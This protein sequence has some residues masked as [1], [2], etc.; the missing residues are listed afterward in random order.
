[1]T[2]ADERPH[3]PPPGADTQ[4]EESWWFDFVAPDGSLA[5]FARLGLWPAAGLA[6]YWA[7]LVGDD[8]PYLLVRDDEVPAPRP[9]RTEIRAEGLWSSLECE[10]PFDHWTVGLEAFAVALDDPDEAWAGERGDRI[11]LGFDLEWEAT[12]PADGGLSSY[13][14][15]C[16]VSGD[17]LVG[18]AERLVFDGTGWRAH[19][20]GPADL[21]NAA[22]PPTDARRARYRAPILAGGQR[23]LFELDEAAG[24]VTSRT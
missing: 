18:P 5:G 14:Q 13:R 1:M 20:W 21:P 17:I 10:T 3:P 23:Y 2:P 7:A 6:W 16:R 9:G 22:P 19:R 4:W 15:A 8:R 12:G 11:G 24:W